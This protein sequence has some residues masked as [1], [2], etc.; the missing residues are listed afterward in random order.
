MKRHDLMAMLAVFA[1]TALF[2]GERIRANWSSPQWE[3]HL[4]YRHVAELH[5]AMSL[6]TAGSWWP[7]LYRPLSTNVVYAICRGPH[8]LHALVLT[9]FML[10]GFLLY[11]IGA[12]AVSVV[13]GL[14][15][16]I[17]WLTRP[18]DV[19]VVLYGCQLQGSLSMLFMLASILIALRPTV[20]T[21]ALVVLTLSALAAK[22]SAA[23]NFLVIG[24]VRVTAFGRGELRLSALR[25]H[26]LPCLLTTAAWIVW[27]SSRV[28]MSD[29]NATHWVYDFHPGSLLA[30]ASF[31]VLTF[32]YQGYVVLVHPCIRETSLPALAVAAHDAGV[33]IALLLLLTA[34]I[35]VLAMS[36]LG[37]IR[38]AAFG[39]MWGFVSLAPTLPLAGRWLLYYG[40]PGHAGLSLAIACLL[41]SLRNVRS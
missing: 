4:F 10:N 31:H 17:A 11:R 23:V 35:M 29:A 36:T 14:L 1:T 16:A 21:Y 18:S 19:E 13:A 32:C 8:T 24:L 27:T 33:H 12:H 30:G 38:W 25:T 28:N 2:H 5:G 26:A 41:V 7:G 37:A 34:S 20:N 39:L 22:E 3:D 15:A 6:W 40:Y 9:V